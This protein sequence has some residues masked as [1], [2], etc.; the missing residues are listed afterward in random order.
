MLLLFQLSVALTFGRSLCLRLVHVRGLIVEFSTE[1]RIK[2]LSV[3][4]EMDIR[5]L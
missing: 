4:I 2:S 3:V 5:N 1:K